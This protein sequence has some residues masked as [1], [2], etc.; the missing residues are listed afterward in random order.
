MEME[1]SISN[2]RRI[3]ADLGV[4]CS[5]FKLPRSQSQ[6][7]RSQG[8]HMPKGRGILLGLEETNGAHVLTACFFDEGQLP[9]N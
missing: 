7:L 2:V 8:A 5:P 1:V 3:L 9:R 4:T 6:G